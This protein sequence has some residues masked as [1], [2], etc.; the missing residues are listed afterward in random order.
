M[1]TLTQITSSSTVNKYLHRTILEH[2][3]NV[4]R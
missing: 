4:L 3:M 2:A 1:P